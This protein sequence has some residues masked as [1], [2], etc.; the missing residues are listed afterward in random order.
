MGRPGTGFIKLVWYRQL[1][2][3]KAI[4]QKNPVLINKML[5]LVHVQV[6]KWSLKSF[7]KFTMKSRFLFFRLS[8][9]TGR[10]SQRPPSS[11]LPKK[12]NQKSGAHKKGW[13][14]EVFDSSS[15]CCP[16]DE[17]IKT[18]ISW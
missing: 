18:W 7:M 13:R 11:T 10:K 17:R 6:G 4:A 8:G 16:K 12:E 9:N 3:L 5:M 15:Q 2:A 14:R 1:S